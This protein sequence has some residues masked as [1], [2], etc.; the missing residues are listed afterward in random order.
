MVMKE[1]E[2]LRNY[3]RLKNTEAIWEL[4]AMYDSTLDTTSEKTEY[5]KRIFWD[6][7]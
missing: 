3:S 5:V 6:N 2:K 4:N 7:Y 1:K